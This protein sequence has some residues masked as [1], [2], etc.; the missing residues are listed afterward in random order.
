MMS[1]FLIPLRMIRMTVVSDTS[2]VLLILLFIV[3]ITILARVSLRRVLL[4]PD[5]D[6]Q[7]LQHLPKGFD[8]LRY[9]ALLEPLLGS[10]THLA[11]RLGLCVPAGTRRALPV[12]HLQN[13]TLG[14]QQ[15]QLG[16]ESP[17]LA[18]T[19]RALPNPPAIV[20]LK[21][22]ADLIL[23]VDLT[24]PM[25]VRLCRPVLQQRQVNQPREVRQHR[26]FRACI[27]R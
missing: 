10:V 8:E 18:A 4:L 1:I 11:A 26:R 13:L 20:I 6:V 19:V 24:D 16:E 23:L 27:Q 3:I 25:N 2:V 17:R 7:R 5:L 9:S 22:V 21:P 14:L 12:F 15:L